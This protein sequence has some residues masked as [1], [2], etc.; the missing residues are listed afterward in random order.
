MAHEIHEHDGLV[1]AETGAWHGLGTIIESAVGPME[2]M[3]IA[4]LDWQVAF[5]DGQYA[6]FDLSGGQLPFITA[7]IRESRTLF[8]MPSDGQPNYLELGTHG[9]RYTPI[10]NN[11]LFELAY[12][13][14]K[15]IK[16]ESAGSLFNGKKIFC[17]LRAPNID[18]AGRDSVDPYLALLN[19]HDGSMALSAMPTS[20][21]IVCNNT[22]SMALRDGQKKMHKVMHTSS[23]DERIA[24]MKSALKLFSQT[25]E[26]F[27]ETAEKLA[28]REIANRQQLMEFWSHCY[29]KLVP[30][31]KD[32]DE[33]TYMQASVETIQSWESK[34]EIEKMT[35]EYPSTNWW[36]AANSVTDWV[37]HDVPSRQTEGWEDRQKWSNLIGGRQEDSITVFKMALAM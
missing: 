21:R 29:T 11:E 13:V 5:A 30:K 22:L 25:R 28:A 6:R 7:D 10:Q 3:R 24:E 8:R 33:M 9:L 2:A 23:K 12:E 32:E 15:E 36:L 34:M 16:V 20:I 4:K 27:I 26:F 14:D 19:S 17:L 37:Q 35:L 1:L 31:R 18:I